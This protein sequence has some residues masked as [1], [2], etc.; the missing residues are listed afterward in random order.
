MYKSAVNNFKSFPNEREKNVLAGNGF[1]GH[2][3]K[4]KIITVKNPSSRASKTETLWGGKAMNA[5]AE[6]KQ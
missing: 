1:C 3:N 4:K 5:R 6:H 2:L